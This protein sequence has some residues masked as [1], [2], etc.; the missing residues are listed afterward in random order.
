LY[1]DFGYE[2]ETQNLSFLSFR[3]FVETIRVMQGDLVDFRIFAHWFAR[4]R[5]ASSLRDAHQLFEEFNGVLTGSPV[6]APY[7]ARED[8]LSLGV[9]R[10]IFT[11]DDRPH[12]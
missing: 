1:Y 10:S 2:N 6:A 12:V 9:R 11:G 7:L 8:Y 3:E 4:H 5:Q